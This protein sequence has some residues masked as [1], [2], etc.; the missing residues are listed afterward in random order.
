MHQ[1][2]LDTGQDL[3]AHCSTLIN[4]P[5]CGTCGKKR[6]EAQMPTRECKQ[7]HSRVSTAY[8]ESCG[9]VVIHPIEEQMEAGTFDWD[10]LEKQLEPFMGGLTPEDERQ[11]LTLG[12][13]HGY[14]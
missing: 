2:V 11:L 10:A 13:M 5:F 8:C 12:Q 3:C 7:C 6:G 9:A 4:T 1:M 14:R